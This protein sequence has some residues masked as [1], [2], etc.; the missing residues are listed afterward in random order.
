MG[1]IEPAGAMNFIGGA[2]H[3]IEI[4]SQEEVKEQEWYCHVG[5]YRALRR[6]TNSGN[7]AAGVVRKSLP[8]GQK[9]A[10]GPAVEC[11]GFML[12]S[13]AVK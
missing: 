6:E 1:L 8:I 10:Q 13:S 7:E 2:L 3:I 4:E 11:G 12:N 5:K 9:R